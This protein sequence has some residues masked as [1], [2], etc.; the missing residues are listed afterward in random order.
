MCARLGPPLVGELRGFWEGERNRETVKQHLGPRSPERVTGTSF[1]K[2][3]SRLQGWGSCGLK[4]RVFP[5]VLCRDGSSGR[6]WGTFLPVDANH[7]VHGQRGRG[8]ER[9]EGTSG[10]CKAPRSMAVQV[11]EGAGLSGLCLDALWPAL[12][13]SLN[14]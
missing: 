14:V 6:P 10:V 7:P 2:R 3:S 12:C 5:E 13:Q 8:Y 4:E 1:Q 11:A 9:T